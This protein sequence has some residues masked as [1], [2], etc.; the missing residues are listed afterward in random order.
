MDAHNP[1][2]LLLCSGQRPPEDLDLPRP[3]APVLGTAI[4]PDLADQPDLSDAFFQQG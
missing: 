3:A 2:A 1:P 4:K